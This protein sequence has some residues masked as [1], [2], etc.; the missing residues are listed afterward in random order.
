MTGDQG[1]ALS[2]RVDEL[3]TQTEANHA[4]IHALQGRADQARDR[5]DAGDARATQ[6]RARIAELERR[7][8]LDRELIADL[9]ADS[10][11][12]KEHAANLA[13]ALRTSRT[14]GAAVGIVMSQRGIAEDNAFDLLRRASMDTNRKL[15]SL[16]E[17]VVRTRDTSSL[18]AR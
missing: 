14:I 6:D 16:A 18:Q 3:G 4:A 9:Q 10:L 5:A 13:E 12:S 7:A 2:G 1:R 17:E 15:R 11:A 8:E